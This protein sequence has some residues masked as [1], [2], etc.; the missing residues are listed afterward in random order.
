MQKVEETPPKLREALETGA[1]GDFIFFS[2]QVY[3]VQADGSWRVVEAEIAAR[4][5]EERGR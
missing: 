3:Q 4:I 1:P 2:N 5:R